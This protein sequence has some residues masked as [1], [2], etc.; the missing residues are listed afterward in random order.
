[1]RTG[2]LELRETCEHMGGLGTRKLGS[3]ISDPGVP[4]RHGGPAAGGSP[5]PSEDDD[6]I[7]YYN[8]IPDNRK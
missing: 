2:D 1:R 3:G 4:T 7:P 5:T 8:K 6:E